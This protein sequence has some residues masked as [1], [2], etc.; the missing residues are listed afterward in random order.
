MAERKPH[1]SEKKK[2]AIEKLAMLI[3]QYPVVGIADMTGLPAEQ[4]QKIRK[5]LNDKMKIYMTKKRLIRIA[6]ENA[7]KD[8]SGI[9]KLNEYLSGIPALIFTK[10]S[11]FKIFNIIKKSKSSAFAKP[12]QLAPKDLI[13][14]AGPTPF[15]PGPVMGELGALGIK[16]GIEGGK[17]AVKT[18][19][20]AARKGEVIKDKIASLLIKF[21]IKPIE[22]GLKVNA[23][24]EKGDVF[25]AEV[26]DI[27]EGVYNE[28]LAKAASWALNLSIEAGYV[29]KDN[30]NI[31]IAKAFANANAI[32][33]IEK[34]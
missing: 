3:K 30:I 29:T 12:G 4:L 14:P 28:K 25:G 33:N 1:I 9:E 23:I 21:G 15:G 31:L 20:V 16:C 7:K 34:S 11:P 22:I 17:I 24:F 32:A 5:S 26:L 19:F 10:E 27:D 13:I 18:D 2:A 8:I 6:I